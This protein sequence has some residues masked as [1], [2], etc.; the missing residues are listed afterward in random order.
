MAA[1]GTHHPAFREITMGTRGAT[2]I[3]VIFGLFSF[4]LFLTGCL[5]RSKTPERV[6]NLLDDKTTSA[7]VEQA[8]MT[9]ANS[10]LFAH[11]Q[12]ISTNSTITLRGSVP[13]SA[14]KEQAA[15]IAGTSP[16]VKEVKNE[17]EV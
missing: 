5:G 11:V 10:N 3:R 15:R 2:K 8:L 16:R 1:M 7:R 12:V 17:L 4:A 13:S 9:G 14:A 6:S